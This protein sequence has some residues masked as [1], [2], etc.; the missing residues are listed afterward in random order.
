M[1]F[2]QS[3]Y[4]FFCLNQCLGHSIYWISVSFGVVEYFWEVDDNL[5]CQR[6]FFK[7]N[8]I[9]FVWLSVCVCVCI[10]HTVPGTTGRKRTSELELQT[11]VRQPL[12]PGNWSKYSEN[13]TSA[14]SHWSIA[15]SPVPTPEFLISCCTLLMLE[16]FYYQLIFHDLVKSHVLNLY[17]LWTFPYYV[18]VLLF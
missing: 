15:L 13:G 16:F 14:F 11:D 5:H 17:F 4:N 6:F 7:K 12:G 9:Y 2:S 10:P 18:V 8:R 3:F 1:P